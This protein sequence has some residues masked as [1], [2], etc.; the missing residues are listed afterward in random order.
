MR[1][2]F[3]KYNYGRAWAGGSL[4]KQKVLSTVRR[5]STESKDDKAMAVKET[6]KKSRR[7]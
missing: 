3:Y 6:N 7:I 5:L 4:E 2:E 1:F